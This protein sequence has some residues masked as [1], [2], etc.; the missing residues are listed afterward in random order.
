MTEGRLFGS[1]RAT[2]A[3]LGKCFLMSLTIV[4]VIGAVIFLLVHV[5]HIGLAN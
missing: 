5:A 4:V 3:L 1:P 2:L